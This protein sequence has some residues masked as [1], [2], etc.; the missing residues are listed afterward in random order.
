MTR[1]VPDAPSLAVSDVGEL[2]TQSLRCCVAPERRCDVQQ[3]YAMRCMQGQRV[4]CCRPPGTLPHQAPP[5]RDAMHLPML[6]AWW[7]LAVAQGEALDPE[8]IPMRLVP[9]R[10]GKNP[11]PGP[12][13]EVPALAAREPKPAAGFARA[14]K[15]ILVG[16]MSMVSTRSHAHCEPD[17]LQQQTTRF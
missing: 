14:E 15:Q 2:R 12:V 13:I 6:L 8:L 17:V 9:T 1:V 5:R 11:A 7:E 4:L 16:R 10:P 3:G